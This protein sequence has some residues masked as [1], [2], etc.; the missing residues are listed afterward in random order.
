MLDFELHN[1]LYPLLTNSGAYYCVSS[2]EGNPMR[3][4]LRNL[5]KAGGQEA[6]QEDRLRL[7]CEQGDLHSC[8]ELL[9]QAQ[10]LDWL[11]GSDQA[12]V[13]PEQSLEQALTEILPKL[14]SEGKVILSDSEGLYVG[15]AG[16]NHETALELAALSADIANLHERHQGLISG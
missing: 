6:L 10:Q 8:S 7:W 3:T 4:L 11:Q 13:W 14:G 15:C 5:L 12:A 9:H 16:Y 2:N 1:G